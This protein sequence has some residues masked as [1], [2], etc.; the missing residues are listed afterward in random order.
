MNLKPVIVIFIITTCFSCN[1]GQKKQGNN[2]I[3]KSGRDSTF[4][5]SVA[6]QSELSYAQIKRHVTA[7]R[8]FSDKLYFT[9]DTIYYPNADYRLVILGT[10]D[11]SVSSHKYLLVYKRDTA[12]NSSMLLI[13]TADDEDYSTDYSQLSFKIFNET[14]FFTREI[15]YIRDKGKKTKVTV[16][17]KFYQVNKNGGIDLLNEKP[18]GIVVPVYEPD[19]DIDDIGQ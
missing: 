12:K 7:N 17:D 18:A 5:D 3:E 6:A 8:D 15:V 11:H 19:P 9:G 10:S 2:L 4:F 1:N 14:Q 16:T 13:G